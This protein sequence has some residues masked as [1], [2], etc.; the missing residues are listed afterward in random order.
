VAAGVRRRRW[1]VAVR[2]GGDSRCGVAGD[3]GGDAGDE[4]R[5]WGDE[6]AALDGGG[7]LCST[8]TKTKELFRSRAPAVYI[9]ADPLAPVRGWNRC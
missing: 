9:G 4:R 7:A 1:P 8:K 3:G 2:S 6:Q 5:R